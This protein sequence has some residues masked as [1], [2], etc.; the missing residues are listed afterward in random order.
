M[1]ALQNF[2]RGYDL[3]SIIFDS[4]GLLFILLFKQYIVHGNFLVNAFSPF[5]AAFLID[6]AFLFIAIKMNRLFQS[7]AKDVSGFSGLI[8]SGAYALMTIAQPVVVTAMLRNFQIFPDEP[9]ILISFFI[10]NAIIFPAILGF[11]TEKTKDLLKY[12]GISLIAGIFFFGSTDIRPN[13]QSVAIL[14]LSIFICISFIILHQRSIK[15]RLQWSARKNRNVPKSFFYKLVFTCITSFLLWS[16][17]ELA[18]SSISISSPE[19][20]FGNKLM[21]LY[22]TGPLLY[23][24]SLMVMPPL[25]WIKVIS[26]I[27]ILIV[28]LLF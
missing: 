27:I 26:G 4:S 24:I 28:S 8:L 16:W 10:G 19:L 14:F 15:I 12:F 20:S 18:V 21:I 2:L 6:A 22:F 13:S 3:D 1:K 11:G 9:F 5:A 7:A 25:R 23:R 17:W